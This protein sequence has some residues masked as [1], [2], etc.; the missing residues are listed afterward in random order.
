MRGEKQGGG[1]PARTSFFI[2]VS[3]NIRANGVQNSGYKRA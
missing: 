1:Y 2:S 3:F